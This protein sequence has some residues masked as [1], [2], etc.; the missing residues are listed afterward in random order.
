M[1][2]GELWSV[3][4]LVIVTISMVDQTKRRKMIKESKNDDSTK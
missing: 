1:V 4:I 3:E 2:S